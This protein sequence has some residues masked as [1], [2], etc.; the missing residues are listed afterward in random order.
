MF[1]K[2]LIAN[3]GEIACR[4]IATARRMGIASVA[5]YSDADRDAPHVRRAD[6]AV[7][8]GAARAAESYLDGEKIIAACRQ[9]GAEAVHPGYGFLAENAA[10]ARA[11]RKS[12]VVFIGPGAD[13]IEVMGD[14]IASKRLARR[15][16]VN[17]IPGHDGAVADAAEAA[18]VAE[19]LG[20]P[21]MLKASAGGGGKGMRIARARGEVAD[22]FARARSEVRASFGDARML[23]EKCIERP[24]HIEIQILADAHGNMLALN[25]R[26][27]SLQRRHQKVIEEAPSPFLD[28]KTRAAMN[29]QA[30]M[31]ARAVKYCSAGTVE[32]VVDAARNFYFL[33]MNTRLQVEHA[34]TELITGIDL[35]E[36]MIRIAAGE[37]LTLAQQDVRINGW[38]IEARIYAENPCCDFLPSSGRLVRYVPPQAAAPMPGNAPGNADCIV[39]IDD[40]VEEGGEISRHYDPMIA[41][42]A[43]WGKDRAAAI[44]ALRAA[45]D[46]YCIR[47]IETNLLFAAALIAHPKFAAGELHTHFIDEEYPGGFARA[48][49]QRM[50]AGVFIAIAAV[51]HHRLRRQAESMCRPPQPAGAKRASDDW[52]VIMDGAQHAVTLSALGEKNGAEKYL[53]RFAGGEFC[54]SE[55][56]WPPGSPVI[57]CNLDGAPLAMLCERRG[58]EYDLAHGGNQISVKVLRPRTAGYYRLMPEK[59]PPDMSRFLLSPM[60]G[61]L[62][63][64]R[65]RAGMRVTAGEELAV[66][67]AMKMENSLRAEHAGVVEKVL[68]TAGA[69]LEAGQVIL[70]FATR[71]GAT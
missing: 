53:A 35:V 48:G 65:A 42:L 30:L 57:H 51:A 1:Q 26:E 44:G 60:P 39:R 14:K 5:V 36:W 70:E 55:F 6:E 62:V 27:C 40:G 54:I 71:A 66:V 24:R 49:K 41:K 20:F 43:A 63:S 3:R 45:L 17:I 4:I 31:L 59:T 61:L 47:G 21:V 28:A 67:E 33:E 38:A 18:R 32:F 29:A 50:N 69:T 52:V 68:V 58:L 23:I 16:G 7:H 22:G 13:A 9:S 10:F 2:I 12:G 11:V 37:K 15:A 19:A 64:L 46:A 25:E 56:R 8:I 34:V